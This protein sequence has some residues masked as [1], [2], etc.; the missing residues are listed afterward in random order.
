MVRGLLA[1][2]I[3]MGGIA[4]LGFGYLSMNTGKGKV[5]LQTLG[6]L[7]VVTY[8]GMTLTGYIP[9][10][11]AL[12]LLNGVAWGF[13]PILFTV[14][15]HLPGIRPREVAV[16]VSF[17]MMMSSGGTALGPL[18]TGFLQESLGDLRVSLLMVSFAALSLT[19]AGT[20][21][22]FGISRVLAG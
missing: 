10:L 3:L 22:R 14:S 1:V 18:V 12:S 17:T 8:V 16:A 7:M 5:I 4:G 13:W 21:L 20:L 19:T 2:S 11:F 6:L 15:F 9:V